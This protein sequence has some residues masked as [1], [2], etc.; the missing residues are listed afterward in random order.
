[1][2]IDLLR[3]A[4]GRLHLLVTSGGCAPFI[5]EIVSVVIG[6]AVPIDEFAVRRDRGEVNPMTR[7]APAPELATAIPATTGLDLVGPFRA[8][9]ELA[10][11]QTFHRLNESGPF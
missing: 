7:D 10:D 8:V 2:G 3:E 1:L 4:G 5:V 6:R 9:E 11:R